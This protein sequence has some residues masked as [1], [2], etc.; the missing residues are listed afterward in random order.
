VTGRIFA[1]P[2]K[3][4]ELRGTVPNVTT[5]FTLPAIWDQEQNVMAYSPPTD[6]TLGLPATRASD[7]NLHFADFARLAP[8][9]ATGA[10]AQICADVVT[11][12]PTLTPRAAGIQTQ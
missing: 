5:K 11:L 6:D 4:I 1:A 3:W 12:A 9:Q 7:P 8:E 10:D 2:R